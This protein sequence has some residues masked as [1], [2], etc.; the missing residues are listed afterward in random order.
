[1]STNLERSWEL[2][3]PYRVSVFHKTLIVSTQTDKE[4]DARH[5]LETM[6]PLPP[7]ALLATHVDHQHFMVPQVESRFRDANCSS[8][9]LNDVL[10]VGN[11]VGI[12]EPLQISEVIVQA[13]WGA[14][15]RSGQ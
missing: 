4:Q 6:N 3:C 9:T 2:W 12:K 5:V 14:G 10:L 11:I 7:F 1:M 15:E 8:P 13:K